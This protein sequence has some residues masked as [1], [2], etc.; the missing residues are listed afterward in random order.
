MVKTPRCFYEQVLQGQTSEDRVK[1]RQN[2]TRTVVE[3]EGLVT[4]IWTS[5]IPT[6]KAD[7]W[8]VVTYEVPADGDKKTLVK[9]EFKNT[10]LAIEFA[11]QHA[12]S[13]SGGCV[14]AFNSVNPNA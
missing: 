3:T 2:D 8:S 12:A 11:R 6:A 5:A 13:K 7:G 9:A 4:V 14:F 10:S 1:E